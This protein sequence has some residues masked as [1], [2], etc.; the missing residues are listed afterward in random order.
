MVKNSSGKSHLL[1]RYLKTNY[2]V[3]NKALTM[4]SRVKL[5]ISH[6]LFI[7]Q[8]SQLSHDISAVCKRENFNTAIHCHRNYKLRM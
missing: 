5:Y 1:K 3:G 7:S 2:S 4:H 8:I 6:E